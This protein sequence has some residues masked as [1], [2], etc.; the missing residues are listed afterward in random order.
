MSD[1]NSNYNVIEGP[2]GPQGPIGPQGLPGERGPQGPQG[3]QGVQ[4]PQGIQGISGVEGEFHLLNMEG[5]NAGKHDFFYKNDSPTLNVRG[6]SVRFTT[7]N[8]VLNNGI[9]E[10]ANDFELNIEGKFNAAKGASFGGLNI[11]SNYRKWYDE[12]GTLI[13]EIERIDFLM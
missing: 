2:Q 13:E 7:G 3:I 9:F 5:G 4:G 8:K 1:E 11:V 6:E 10:S 12:N